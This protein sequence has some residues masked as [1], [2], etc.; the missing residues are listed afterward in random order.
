MK[1]CRVK[2]SEIKTEENAKKEQSNDSAEE[3]LN[4]NGSR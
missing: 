2:L 1:D 4:E 3:S